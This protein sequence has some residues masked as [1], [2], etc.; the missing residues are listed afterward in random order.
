[1]ESERRPEQT[2]GEARFLTRSIFFASPYD[3]DDSVNCQ[4]PVRQVASLTGALA[5]FLICE[6]DRPPDGMP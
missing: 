6:K 3:A 2:G 1:M 4:S 5:H